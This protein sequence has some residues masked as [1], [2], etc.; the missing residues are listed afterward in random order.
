MIEN[1]AGDNSRV[2]Y[3]TVQVYWRDDNYDDGEHVQG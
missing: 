1:G 2:G 3:V